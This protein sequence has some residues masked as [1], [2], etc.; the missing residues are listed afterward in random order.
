MTKRPERHK[1]PVRA[2]AVDPVTT[3]YDD[4]LTVVRR[5][6]FSGGGQEELD[7]FWARMGE[8]VEQSNEAQA[9]TFEG[10]IKAAESY[11]RAQPE[12]ADGLPL[13]KAEFRREILAKI[14]WLRRIVN[15][16]LS[17]SMTVENAIVWGIQL[18]CKIEDARWRFNRG[19]DARRGINQR[20]NQRKAIA[21]AARLKRESAAQTNAEFRSDVARVRQQDVSASAGAIASKLLRRYGRRSGSRARDLEALR[22]R[23][24]RALVVLG[25]K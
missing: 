3:D 7:A 4:G 6:T 2:T 5:V 23:V 21:S 10:C 1:S 15:E 18:G 25:L 16:G 14:A 13:S 8:W 22:K 9:W 12:E 11:W 19:D 20:A 24:A 17:A